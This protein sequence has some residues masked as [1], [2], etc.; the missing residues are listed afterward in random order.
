MT[1]VLTKNIIDLTDTANTAQALSKFE[2]IVCSESCSKEPMAIVLGNFIF[3]QG[4]MARLKSL[5]EQNNIQIDIIYAH[6]TQTQ[7]AGLAAGLTVSEKAP[8]DIILEEFKNSLSN[9]NNENVQSQEI[10]TNT[11]NE[12]IQQ[13]N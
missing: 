6:T 5:S 11:S 1:N 12:S 9:I 2:K 4:H 10:T 7:L 3:T 8:G 13:N